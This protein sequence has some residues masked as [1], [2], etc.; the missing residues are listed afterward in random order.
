MLDLYPAGREVRVALRERPDAVQVIR[1]QDHCIGR[2]W[3][4]DTHAFD[5]VAQGKPDGIVTQDGTATVSDDRE[6]VGRTG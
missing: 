3:K 4:T 6:E 5:C 1:H 2:E